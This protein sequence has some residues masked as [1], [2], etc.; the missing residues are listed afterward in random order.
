MSATRKTKKSRVFRI[1]GEATHKRILETAGELFAA[2]G[3]AETS[4]K[5]IAA[6]AGVDLASIN[7]HF[8]S[9]GGLYQA[10]L[11]EAHRRLISMESL[12]EVT[13]ADLPARDKLKRVIEGIVEAAVGQQGWHSRVLVREL[14]SPTSHLQVLQQN[15]VLPKFKVVL[16]ILREITSIPPDDPALFRC[17]VSVMAP[18]AMM[19]VAGRNVPAVVEAV[20]S[21]PREALVAHLYHFA[22]GGLNAIG[23]EHKKHRQ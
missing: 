7:Y 13:A 8:G 11:A 4:N 1:D 10:V 17:A 14:M 5:A 23:Q 19:L 3:F 9:R 20:S 15:E 21:T 18:C 6:K 2:F 22:I 16:G 12:Q